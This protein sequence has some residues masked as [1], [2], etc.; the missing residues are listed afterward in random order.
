MFEWISSNY[1]YHDKWYH[2]PKSFPWFHL[3]PYSTHLIHG[4][5]VASTS[6]IYPES[7]HFSISPP[8]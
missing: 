1:L 7:K 2:S 8:V 6:K 3:I 5:P 4:N